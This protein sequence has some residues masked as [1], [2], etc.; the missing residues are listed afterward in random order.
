MF[1]LLKIYIGFSILLNITFASGYQTLIL[2]EFENTSHNLPE[3]YLRHKLPD[4]VREYS[5]D[6]YNIEYAG[7]IEPY[8]GLNNEKYKDALI[9]LGKF[10]IYES[11]IDISISLYDLTTWEKISNNTY[12]C[13]S[14]NF[15]CIENNLFQL[16]KKVLL[17]LSTSKQSQNEI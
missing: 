11:A 12:Q 6:Y 10:N 16:I 2:L 1:K 3:D 13:I 14:S 7:K 8:L 5:K 9:L 17:P 4:L 15:R